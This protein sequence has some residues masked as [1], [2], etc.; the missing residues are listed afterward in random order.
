[1][2]RK[3]KKLAEELLHWTNGSTKEVQM[4]KYI[5]DAMRGDFEAMRQVIRRAKKI[6]R[7][8]IMEELKNA[9]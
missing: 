7:L 2:A 4:K 1:M 6:E 5:S 9:K 3:I 8:R